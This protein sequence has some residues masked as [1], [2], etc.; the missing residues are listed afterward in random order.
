[1]ALRVGKEEEPALLPETL[2]HCCLFSSGTANVGRG[3]S[4]SSEMYGRRS[5][6]CVRRTVS[7]CHGACPISCCRICPIHEE[8]VSATRGRDPKQARGQSSRH[9]GGGRERMRDGAG[10]RGRSKDKRMGGPLQQAPWVGPCL[11]QYNAQH[12][13]I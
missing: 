13:D 8:S 7:S 3:A 10:E 9:G 6:A 1:M 2:H 4:R 5:C 12:R 11:C